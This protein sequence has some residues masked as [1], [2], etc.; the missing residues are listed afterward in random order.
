MSSPEGGRPAYV[1]V[2]VVEFAAHTAYLDPATGIG[3]LVLPRADS[4]VDALSDPLVEAAWSERLSDFGDTPRLS[5]HTADRRRA[6]DHLGAAGWSLLR[7][8]AGDVEVAGRTS[9]DRQAV[10]IYG[11][12]T[13][14]PPTLEA[15]DYAIIALDMA[16]N[17]H[18]HSHCNE[19]SAPW[20]D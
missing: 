12:P 11:P 4:D 18:P 17:L 13:M 16:A 6:L 1:D 10:C 7:D 8:E 20:P 2:T 5:L 19:T 3:Y 9:D 14:E 15:L